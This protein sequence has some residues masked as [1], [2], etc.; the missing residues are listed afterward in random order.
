MGDNLFRHGEAPMDRLRF[1]SKTFLASVFIVLF[2]TRSAEP[3]EDEGFTMSGTVLLGGANGT[4]G[5]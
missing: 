4:Q 5:A 2:G 3:Q 1:I